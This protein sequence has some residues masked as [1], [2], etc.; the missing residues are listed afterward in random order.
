MAEAVQFEITDMATGQVLA[1][2]TGEVPVILDVACARL[3]AQLAANG[4][5]AAAMRFRL[6]VHVIG[7][8][9]DRAWC[10]ERVHR[11]GPQD[12]AF[13]PHVA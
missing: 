10:G 1:A 8:G 2:E 6:A 13:R 11:P 5:G 9:G 12:W 3:D 4:E 7:P